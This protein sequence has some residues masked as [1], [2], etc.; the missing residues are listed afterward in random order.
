MYAHGARTP[1]RQVQRVAR[2][3]LLVARVAGLVDDAHQAGRKGSLVVARGDAHVLRHTAAKRVRGNIQPAAFKI[4]TQQAH[5][6]HTQ[7]ALLV[8]GEGAGCGHDGFILLLGDDAA[9]QIGK[10]GLDVAKQ[11]GDGGLRH[12]GLKLVHQGFV[13]RGAGC[14]RQ[15]FGLLACQLH[16]LAEIAQ[17]A[18]PVVG[19]ALRAPGVFA[20]GTGQTLGL[21]QVLRQAVDQ[22][23]LA[24]HLGQAGLV[25]VGQLC[26][27]RLGKQGLERRVGQRLVHQHLQLGHGGGTCLVALGG[28]HGGLVPAGDGGQVVEVVQAFEGGVQCGQCG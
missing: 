8:D 19:L 4:K 22:C 3:A 24:L 2:Q 18:L 14:V 15:K 9:D 23:P 13:R 20:A 25:G 1:H 26:R 21:D 28:H 6:F 12:A 5:H 10:P 16:H 17:K 7:R 27:R 11:L